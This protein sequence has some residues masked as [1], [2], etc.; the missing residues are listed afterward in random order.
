MKQLDAYT[1]ELSGLHLIEASAGTGKTH[2][3]TTLYLRAVVELG[4]LPE[5]IL[6]VTFTR[7]AT[8]EL[9]ERIR[10]RLRLAQACFDGSEPTGAADM[11]AYLSAQVD[12]EQARL[13]LQRALLVIDQA[14]VTTIHGFCAG[15]LEQ[16]AFESRMP[17]GTELVEVLDPLLNEVVNDFMVNRV[18]V[19][20]Q[21]ELLAMRA[22]GI[23]AA[24]L[25]KLGQAVIA[26]DNCLLE[27]QLSDATPA[28]GA[29][30]S[31]FD[32]RRA[33]ARAWLDKE[34]H[35]RT[36]AGLNKTKPAGTLGKQL[37]GSVEKVRDWLSVPFHQLKGDC[38]AVERLRVLAEKYP[39]AKSV[40]MLEWF[41][42]L[43]ACS[44]GYAK[45]RWATLEAG[46]RLRRDF[47][48][49]MSR[50]F[51]SRKAIRG[52]QS[53]D[54]LLRHL[55]DA[56]N[57]PAGAR[58]TASLR[59]RYPL[60]LIDEF[61][62]TDPIQFEVFSRIYREHAS[63]FLI[64]DPKQ[65]IYA[66]RGADVENYRT[67]KLDE[68]VQCHT[69]TTNWRSDPGLIE[70]VQRLY[71]GHADPFLGA[72][73]DYV[74]VAARPGASDLVAPDDTKL[75]GVR[76]HWL[77]AESDKSGKGIAKYRARQL[78]IAASVKHVEQLLRT[79]PRGWMRTVRASEIAVL[80]RTNR[81]C[82]SMARALRAEGIRCVQ[83]SD[84]S[85]LDTDAASS[86]GTLLGALL[87]PS[88]QRRVTSWLI[89]PLGGKS[90]A[91]IE[92][93]RL[94]TD[95]WEGWVERLWRYR[96]VWER[97]GLLAAVVRLCDELEVKVRI[98]SQGSG[99]RFITDLFH[100]AELTQAAAKEQRMTLEGQFE[101]LARVRSGE[102]DCSVE[103]QQ[104]RIE[105]DSEAVLLTTV[106]RSKGLE[107]PFV[108]CPCLWDGGVRRA[109]SLLSYR[110]RR[111]GD[112]K[113]REVLHL[114][115]R[116]LAEGAEE[117]E[118]SRA[119]RL[120]E[121]A[122]LL[123]V[124]L[125][126]A[127]HQV[128]IVGL[129]VAGLENSALGQLLFGARRD[130]ARDCGTAGDALADTGQADTRDL[131]ARVFAGT[132]VVVGDGD[133]NCAAEIEPKLVDGSRLIAPQK[134]SR[135]VTATVQTTSYSALTAVSTVHADTGRDVDALPEPFGGV[136]KQGTAQ[137]ELRLPMV[138]LPPGTR[139]GE[140]LHAILER[141]DFQRFE[142][143]GEELDVAGILDRFG[144]PG[145]ALEA[146]VRKGI[147]GLLNV[148]LI[149]G[150][151]ELKLVNVAPTEK[152]AEF[153]FLMK[154]E[155]LDVARLAFGL[156]PELTGLE[157]NYSEDLAR[158]RFDP[159]T[160]YLRGFIDLVF[161]HAGRVYVVDYK[162][163][164]LGNSTE[165]FDEVRLKLEMRRHHYP[166]QA[167]LYAAA[168][169]RWLRAV[170]RDYDYGS[171][172]GGVF[173]LFLRGILPEMG[174]KS[175]VFF[176]RP[177][178][179]ALGAFE[180]ILAGAAL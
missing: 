17:F 123:Y 20:A 104:L 25:R 135:I 138:E 78:S 131:L 111:H 113:T 68:R 66:F 137:A 159:V 84:S 56:L 122:R 157:S 101:W 149:A 166:V 127:K 54:D 171:H 40:E 126:R 35:L 133:L 6:V 96:Q 99:E 82:Q 55:R 70:G 105:A 85:V 102:T 153:E 42:M 141:A 128:V 94:D 14:S 72:G 39:S 87:Q 43:E 9:G 98:L 118:L 176:H 41:S 143:H 63:L 167:A 46:V 110:Q 90:P 4:L 173:Y 146:N 121:N 36:L 28:L 88:D 124:A 109:E 18:A 119:E 130:S 169:D 103:G 59:R 52:V 179:E 3:I 30:V 89:D 31:E 129:R 71:Q 81:E 83:T 74:E 65:S 125:T 154:V 136:P 33:S 75:T 22:I 115:P 108:I 62:D 44:V 27:P 53:F 145:A 86:L 95:T 57:G 37:A 48:E 175:G 178:R 92:R 47:V 150:Q 93:L 106:H 139:T 156:R 164:A 79:Q 155:G 50:E 45:L 112:A 140:A 60:A 5:Q 58:L 116:L 148:E 91:E 144:L 120:R 168:I 163:N 114:E 1:V 172:F 165:S 134:L 170:R 177:S 23:D 117:F 64:G 161:E 100:V 21:V 13:R 151:P 67:A 19:L 73:I 80:G 49:Y 8:G 69:L 24:G 12:R 132:N 38:E 174:A 29:A 152:K 32:S 142:Q 26:R 158:L 160:G 7:A 107:F 76:I 162:S 16:N 147:V 2:A 10:T 51:E 11:R 34:A 77:D 61:Q 97:S 180:A 15:V